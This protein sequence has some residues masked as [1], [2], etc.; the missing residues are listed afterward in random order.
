MGLTS[1]KADYFLAAHDASG[2]SSFFLNKTSRAKISVQASD[3]GANS[4]EDI[5]SA[6]SQARSLVW[7]S[8]P[9]QVPDGSVD[10]RIYRM[11]MDETGGLIIRGR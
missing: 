11:K 1:N 8:R 6:W 2:T 4:A 10:I 3:S 9:Y 7:D 5:R